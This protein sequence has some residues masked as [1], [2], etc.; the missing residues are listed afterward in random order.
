MTR[1]GRSVSPRMSNPPVV[2]RLLARTAASTSNTVTPNLRSA[3]GFSSTW[4]CFFSPPRMMISATPRI[5]SSRGRMTAWARVPR[6]IG[7]VAPPFDVTPTCMICPMTELVGVISG[8][9]PGGISARTVASRSCT[10]CRATRTS[11]CHP[12]ST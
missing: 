3:S 5:L 11:T 2:F 6:S 9:T 4:Y 7:V 1:M 8:R 12:N 10:V